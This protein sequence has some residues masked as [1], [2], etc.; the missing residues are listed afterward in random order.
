MFDLDLKSFFLQS[1]FDMI[2]LEMKYKFHNL[3]YFLSG[4]LGEVL[5]LFFRYS[6]PCEVCQNKLFIYLVASRA[7]GDEKFEFIC[8]WHLFVCAH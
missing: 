5:I 3:S 6:E 4:Y 2:E 7:V 1:T 8:N